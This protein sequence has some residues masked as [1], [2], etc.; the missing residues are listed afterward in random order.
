MAAG[1][2]RCAVA[3]RSQLVSAAACA[4]LF[5]AAG[6]PG[7][8]AAAS[9]Q[10]GCYRYAHC[11][12]EC[13][14][15]NGEVCTADAVGPGCSAASSPGRR[16]TCSSGSWST[17]SDSTYSPNRQ[18]G[19][20]V[21]ACN[22]RAV[23]TALSTGGG[24]DCN[25]TLGELCV[26]DAARCPAANGAGYGATSDG[27]TCAPRCFAAAGCGGA[28]PLGRECALTAAC[29]G[30]GGYACVL[31]TR[32]F[33]ADATCGGGSCA[34][35]T[36]CSWD[37][38]G[39]SGCAAGSPG[40]ACVPAAVRPQRA[41]STATTVGTLQFDCYARA[42]CGGECPR[43]WGANTSAAC[44]RASG[45]AALA[46]CIAP[47]IYRCTLQMPPPPPPSG[48]AGVSYPP[49]RSPPPSP[50]PPRPPSPP[51]PPMPPPSPPACIYG[52]GSSSGCLET[53]P[54]CFAKPDCGYLGCPPDRECAWSFTVCDA[55][56]G[57]YC[58]L[59]AA[60]QDFAPAVP[61]LALA[62][63]LSVGAGLL[64]ALSA[65]AFAR[66]SLFD[67]A[68]ARHA[69]RAK[70]AERARLLAAEEEPPLEE[71][72]LEEGALEQAASQ[73]FDASYL[74][75][76]SS[77]AIPGHTSDTLVTGASA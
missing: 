26:Q 55:P 4:L 23:D 58:R 24:L 1:A 51:P 9:T 44:V 32:C 68:E 3:S 54:E 64:L 34:L 74:P 46:G 56:G 36:Q 29:G 63:G 31:P 47:Y 41:M 67:A 37:G 66:D 14:A 11:D 60:P 19:A 49:P 16:Y 42:D 72:A 10:R 53:R 73:R 39:A 13:S 15:M 30:S 76:A 25:A 12:F 45:A 20:R 40:Y 5:L 71:G 52:A 57:Y 61:H 21:E 28:C 18:C 2:P 8:A 43:L 17:Y 6:P 33:G 7:A 75:R 62:V 70:E 38:V 69:R 59:P 65:C 50:Q 77:G 27:F 35:G 22:Q 48:A